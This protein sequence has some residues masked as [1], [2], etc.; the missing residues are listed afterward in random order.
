MCFLGCLVWQRWLGLRRVGVRERRQ[1]F[2]VI[3]VR[4][5]ESLKEG[6]GILVGEEG[7]DF[8][9]INKVEDCKIFLQE[10]E[11]RYLFLEIIYVWYLCV[12]SVDEYIIFV[13]RLEKNYEKGIIK[14]L[15]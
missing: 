13:I 9:V 1:E 12:N 4:N 11:I 8:R 14:M 15:K 10:R 7:M 6:S 5:D 2:I 3:L